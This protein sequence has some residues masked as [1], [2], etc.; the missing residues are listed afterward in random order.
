MIILRGFLFK[1]NRNK[2]T[3]RVRINRIL[4]NCIKLK[5]YEKDDENFFNDIVE[6]NVPFK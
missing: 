1:D 6:D 2:Y 4:T 3:Q 5:L